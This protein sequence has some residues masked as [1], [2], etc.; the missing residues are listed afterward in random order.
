MS[1]TKL[2]WKK[3]LPVIISTILFVHT[4]YQLIRGVTNE[5]FLFRSYMTEKL[6]YLWIFGDPLHPSI[7]SMLLLSPVMIIGWL[8]STRV[9][10][11]QSFKWR[12]VQFFTLVGAIL[13]MFLLN[14]TA[15]I[16][17]NVVP[18][19]LQR[20]EMITVSSDALRDVM[21]GNTEAFLLLVMS[22]PLIMLGL[23]SLYLGGLFNQNRSEIVEAF[24][25]Y[26]VTS[27]FF[28]KLTKSERDTGLPDVILGPDS[29]TKE[30][31]TIPG[32]D[33]S[34][35][36]MIVG[37]IG[38][39]KTAAVATPL[40]NQDL[41]HFTKYINDFPSVSKRDD[42]EQIKGNY[43]NGL[44]VI[45]PSN[46]LCK[47][48]YK[49]CLAHGI[50]EEA[51][52]YVDPS[53]E[54]TPS[55]NPLQGP[56]DKVAESMT[57]VVEGLG[58]NDNFFFAQAQ[59]AHFKQYIYLL[60]LHSEEEEPTLAE[61]YEMYNDVQL[62]HKMHLKL[63]GRIEKYAPLAKTEDEK[64]FW[65]VVKDTD[66][67]FDANVIPVRDR[68]NEV[69]KITSGK[70]RGEIEYF[71]KKGE[72][73]EGLRNILSD[74][75]SNVLLRRV[76]FKKSSFDF[77][78]HLEAGGILLVNTEKG[79]LMELSIVLGKM[80]LLSVQNAVFRRQPKISPYHSIYADEFPEYIYKPF[81]N[82]PAQSRKYKANIHVI[83]QTIAQLADDYGEYFMHTLL[84]TFRNKVVYADVS[85]FDAKTFSFLFH[86][87]NNY[88]ESTSEQS[89]SPLQDSPVSRQGSS[90]QQEKESILTPGDIL[91][92]KAFEAAAK[93]VV[94]NESK[95][96]R[97]I[98]AN[99][100]PREE[101]VEAKNQVN[102]EAAA[103][104]LEERERLL[105][106]AK[107]GID[108]ETNIESV[109]EQEIRIQ[110]EVEE[111]KIEAKVLSQTLNHKHI[112]QPNSKLQYGSTPK[113]R[114]RRASANT[115]HSDILDSDK[116]DIVGEHRNEIS[117]QTQK[118]IA[119]AVTSQIETEPV[120]S[121]S[122]I[123]SEVTTF[124]EPDNSV[125]E[126]LDKEWED[127]LDYLPESISN[128]NHEV[129][130]DLVSK[131]KV[132]VSVPTIKEENLF[133]SL[134]ESMDEDE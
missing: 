47:D 29:D 112:E 30:M 88:V 35:N 115:N 122:D 64:N 21:I 37:S 27:R 87:K 90:Y 40:I 132:E 75:S 54:N 131:P 49:L 72:F 36:T 60:K 65:D 107:H 74:I 48:V 77:D 79:S 104:W 45:E 7:W 124:K 70:Y 92:L 129:V 42:Y 26:E 120:R 23:L 111:S 34:L 38:T 106:K 51:I 85:E 130:K 6:H 93:I 12:L 127:G 58:E 5:I 102:P 84:T 83:A 69:S 25:E 1:S 97:K 86:E 11:Y 100:V 119:A 105:K 125:E 33:R 103:Y 89:V 59:R 94:N 118:Q 22:L 17:N 91:S 73:I 76:L 53:N 109:S 41:D 113:P 39:G 80:V 78:A 46:D 81:R 63:K 67:W 114:I 28:Q 24:K 16:Y 19:F 31:V 62:V 128:N 50:P 134:A 116:T 133:D 68:N 9:R 8:F 14:V 61:L 2:N 52:Y 56:V 18:Y 57:M 95:P 99:F 121:E 20:S 71:D 3:K 32:G 13:S 110:K 96:A 43:L 101:F 117:N 98:K 55:I 108:S 15:S 82:F 44:V 66:R 126:N 10:Y 123:L 4:L